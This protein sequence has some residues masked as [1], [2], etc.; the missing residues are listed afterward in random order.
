MPATAK[1]AAVPAEPSEALPEWDLSALYAAP[2][3]PA[4]E[5]DLAWAGER[6]KAFQQA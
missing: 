4:L 3:D 5:A 1:P 6:A 2:D